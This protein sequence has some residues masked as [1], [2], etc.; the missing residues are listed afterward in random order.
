MTSHLQLQARGRSFIEICYLNVIEIGGCGG[1]EIA[2]V[3]LVPELSLQ[4]LEHV[5]D[6]LVLAPV[7]GCPLG[8]LA[9]EQKMPADA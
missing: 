3:L 5:E 6:G 9:V 1:S 4:A 8:V 2:L 7:E